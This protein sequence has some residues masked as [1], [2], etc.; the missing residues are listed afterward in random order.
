MRT[1]TLKSGKTISVSS[2][3]DIEGTIWVNK[4][5][6]RQ[7]KLLKEERLRLRRSLIEAVELKGID[8]C[9]LR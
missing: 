1:L 3:E 5:A 4:I 7:S 2:L 8:K 9:C 6:Y